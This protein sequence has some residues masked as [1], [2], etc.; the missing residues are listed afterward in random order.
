[1]QFV[2]FVIIIILFIFFFSKPAISMLKQVI[3]LTFQLNFSAHNVGV[4]C[5]QAIA[6]LLSHVTPFAANLALR[7][8]G[9]SVHAPSLFELFQSSLPLYVLPRG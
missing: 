1:M 6:S 4:P 9:H 7:G 5:H 2:I 3:A 8:K